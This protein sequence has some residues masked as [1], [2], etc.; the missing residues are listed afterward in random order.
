MKAWWVVI[1]TVLLAL[2]LSTTIVEANPS[3][4]IADDIAKMLQ[5]RSVAVPYMYRILG[6]EPNTA[7]FYWG[8][9]HIRVLYQI[10]IERIP[11]PN[12]SEPDGLFVMHSLEEVQVLV[13]EKL[14][15]GAR[16]SQI[17][18]VLAPLRN[19]EQPGVY[20]VWV[21]PDCGQAQCSGGGMWSF[22]YY[23]DQPTE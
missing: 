5:V 2:F 3:N 21:S 11:L 18:E 1:A 16:P 20:K 12:P 23:G 4:G 8:F 7:H 19:L 13:D 15:G 6:P 9:H 14:P 10:R 22:T 17:S